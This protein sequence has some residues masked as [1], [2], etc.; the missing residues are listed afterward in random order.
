M[1][2]IIIALLLITSTSIFSQESKWLTDY[3]EAAKISKETKKPIL[4]FFTGSDWCGWC[5][6]LEK[7]VLITNEFN[8]WANENVVLLKLD[9][10]RKTKLSKELRVQNYGLQRAFGVSGYPA[11]VLLNP[12]QGE[13]SRKNLKELGRTGYVTGGPNKWIKSIDKYLP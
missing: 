7:E 5:K 1:K 6:R 9:F 4:A 10:P 2:K 13:N 8:Q 11:M 12:G 3:N